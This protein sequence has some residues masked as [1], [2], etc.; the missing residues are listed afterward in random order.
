[1][2]DPMAAYTAESN[3]EAHMVC[4]MLTEA[5]IDAMVVEDVSQVA[6]W[7]GGLLPQVH[8]PQVWIERAQLSRAQPLL[9]T[10]SRKKFDRVEAE[11]NEIVTPIK[12][13]CEDCKETTEFPASLKGS[14]EICSHCGAFVDVGEDET[15]NDWKENQSEQAVEGDADDK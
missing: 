13:V 1:M 12:V 14:T 7:I 6:V 3:F 2:Q 15:F 9:D 5:S 10:Y 8:K 11:Y 4:S